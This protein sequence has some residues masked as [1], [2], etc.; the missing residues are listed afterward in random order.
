M[1]SLL[2]VAMLTASVFAAPPKKYHFELTAVTPKPEVK[3]DVAKIAQ[4]RVADQFKKALASNP[5]LVTA[6]EGAPDPLTKADAYRRFLAQK[7]IAASY[8]VSVEITDASEQIEPMEGK[9]NSQRMVVHV[10]IHVLGE[11]IPGRTMGFTGDGQATVKQEI[12]MKVRD[13]DR[14]YAWD[15]AAETAVNDALKT[16]FAKLSQPHAKP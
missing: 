10:G 16:C 15:G 11:T 14:N 12:G 3:A 5:Q 13:V 4:E 1:K 9:S 2:V 8:L 6:L 7:G